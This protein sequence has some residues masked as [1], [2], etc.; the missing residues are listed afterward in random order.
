MT[1]T[2]IRLMMKR[3]TW[4]SRRSTLL[5]LTMAIACQTAA[6]PPTDS[7]TAGQAPQKS[8]PL[9]GVSAE[10]LPPEQELLRLIEMSTSTVR[11]LRAQLVYDRT[12]QLVGDRQRRFGTLVYEMGPPA[13]FA[14]HFDRLL[15]DRRMDHD[16]RWYIFDGQWLAERYDDEKLFIKR[17]VVPPPSPGAEDIPPDPLALGAGPFALPI[18]LKREQV[19]K[20]FDVS[21]TPPA[22]DDSPFHLHLVPKPDYP[23]E[24]TEVDLW[25]ERKR[26]LPTRVRTIDDSENETV[27]S[28][29][30]FRVNEPAD[31]NVI[32]TSPPSDPGWRI[33]IKPW[34]QSPHVDP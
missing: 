34:Q 10:R 23:S 2:P 16:D 13:R 22:N 8:I 3:I 19:V 29:S 33:E 26:L 28:L 11:T 27:V 4:L 14:V 6:Q 1:A 9:I 15:V 18:G 24:F 32:N 17:Q 5:C 20:R 12:Q 7:P 31:T 25:Y 30:Q 21:L